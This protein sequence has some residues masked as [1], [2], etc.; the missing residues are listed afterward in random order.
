MTSTERPA[1]NLIGYARVSSAGQDLTI[2][3]EALRAAGCAII[4]SEKVSGTTRAGRG[5]LQTLIDYLRAGD[6]VVVTRIDRL[7]RS[8][9]DLSNIVHE[10]TEKGAF[11][12]ATEQSVDTSTPAGRAFLGMLGIFAE[13]ET[14]IRKERQRE[15]IEKAKEN[16]VYAARTRA[17]PAMEKKDAVLALLDKGMT[18]EATARQLKIDRS[19]VYRI[20]KENRLP[21]AN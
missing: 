3:T 5:E 21:A 18:K 14:N 7:A 10:I 15:G 16:G 17:R 12:R 6:T 20:I 13:F 4:R 8:L 1:G 2:Q 9:R 19:S 11:L